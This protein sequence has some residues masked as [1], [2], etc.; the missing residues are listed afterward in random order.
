MALEIEGSN[1]FAHP[2]IPR[3]V[4]FTRTERVPNLS[5]RN[6]KFSVK[7]E[8]YTNGNGWI[9]ELTSAL[10]RKIYAF[11][12]AQTR[13]GRTGPTW[14]YLI[15]NAGWT[16]IDLGTPG[17]REVLLDACGAVGLIEKDLNNIILTHGHS[18]H[19]GT[20]WEFADNEVQI[21]AH[22]YYQALKSFQPRAIQ[23]RSKTALQREFQRLVEEKIGKN[24]S[25]LIEYDEE[26]LQRKKDMKVDRALIDGDHV[27]DI[28]VLATPG[29]SPDEIC[30]IVDDVVFSGDHVLP[31]ITPHPTMK[32]IFRDD[33]LKTIPDH[34][35]DASEFSGLRTYLTSLDK[36]VMLGDEY[37]VLPAHRL[38]NKGHFNWCRVGRAAQI[39]AHHHHRFD[40]LKDRMGEGGATLEDL[41][42]VMFENSKLV[43]GNIVP[44]MAEVVAH[45]E[46]LEDSGEIAVQEDGSISKV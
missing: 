36:I 21:F 45:L 16:L 5:E 38:Y 11:G 6:I 12:I 28:N 3:N 41:T 33:V 24:T 18:D 9:L 22:E 17:S 14:S 20:A 25:R 31:E 43:G 29:H 7:R 26:Y 40:L 30:L 19:D 32:M 27:G 44:A 39:I 35:R 4:K 13:R 15:D 10:G 46:F 1:P 2:I 42:E 23:D 34:L 8:G 37:N